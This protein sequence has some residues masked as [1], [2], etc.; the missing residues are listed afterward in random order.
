MTSSSIIDAFV[1]TLGLDPSKYQA[2][3]RKF[4]QEQQ[5]MQREETRRDKES[6]DVYKKRADAVNEVKKQTLGLFS[7][8]VGAGGI[9]KFVTTQTANLAHLGRTAQS[10]GESVKN[11]SAFQ[12]VIQRNGGTAD[13]AASSLANLTATLE[14]YKATG[15]I[16]TL[17][18]RSLSA[19]GFSRN[20]SALEIYKKFAKFSE[21]KDAKFV[22]FIGSNLGFDEAAINEA[23]KGAAQVNKD[24]AE[25]Y[26]MGLPDQAQ[27]QKVQALQ[28]AF[29]HLRQELTQDANQ[30]LFSATPGLTA[31]LDWAADMAGQFPTATKAVLG[32]GVAL[33]GLGATTTALKVLKTLTGGGAKAAAP[34]AEAAGDTA[35]QAVTNG[36]ARAALPALLR[37]GGPLAAGAWMLFHP[38]AANVG[39]DELVARYHAG[40]NARRKAAGKPPLN[41][42]TA[43]E[44]AL[45]MARRRESF[46]SSAY[47]DRNAFR[48]GFGSDT[49]TDPLTGRVTK[50]TKD[51]RG[52]TREMAE[53]DLKRRMLTEFMPR[54]QR[55]VGSAWDGFSS[56]TQAALADVVYNYGHLPAELA[57]SA[58]RGDRAGMA[59]ALTHLG[60]AGLRGNA[61]RRAE[62]ARMVLSDAGGPPGAATA[63]AGAGAP[64][65]TTTVQIDTVEVH[66]QATDAQG[67]ARDVGSAL[68]NQI[69]AQVQSGLF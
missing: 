12:A 53:A 64:S 8:I 39:E 63:A 4:E 25:S 42:P 61:S 2:E 1:V 52:V 27:V 62:E 31:W 37:I 58:T 6:A 40:E 21:G 59:A 17:Q 5:R 43:A 50:V 55:A 22:N 36:G 56:A 18:I 54:A 34:V 66:T 48:V 57:A 60:A 9:E 13:S 11:L 51:T 44:M 28:N 19:I 65:S 46:K 7:V 38:T 15:D 20:D 47:W 24:L 26:K 41:T 14:K 49:V 45:A 10:M 30:L 29:F 69:P 33:T 67:I 3:V 32:L 16:D 68:R 23:M 35:L